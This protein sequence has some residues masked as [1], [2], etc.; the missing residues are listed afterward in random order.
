[1]NIEEYLSY[2]DELTN[3]CI[4]SRN[5]FDPNKIYFTQSS[6]DEMITK[7]DQ[8]FFECLDFCYENDLCPKDIDRYSFITETGIFG[9][10]SKERKISIC[11]LDNYI[12]SKVMIIKLKDSCEKMSLDDELFATHPEAIETIRKKPNGDYDLELIDFSC[13][14]QYCE[15]EIIEFKKS[16]L[17]I[18]Y[19]INPKMIPWLQS[20]FPDS[21]LYIRIQSKKLFKSP[22]PI[23]SL[24]ECLVPANPNWIK[25]L[26]IYN[27][28]YTGASY[29]IPNTVDSTEMKKYYD[30]HVK[31]IEQLDVVFK[32][33]GSGNLSGMIEELNHREINHEY[34]LGFCVH[35]DTDAEFG[36][37]CNDAVL[38]HLD[39]ALNYY[40]GKETIKNRRGCSLASGEKVTD[41]STRRHLLRLEKIPF[42]MIF[43]ITYEFFEGKVLF[44]EW[45]FQLLKIKT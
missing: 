31:G 21:K 7:K 16:Y 30:Y 13:Y 9:D 39:L 36:S 45:I 25:K 33:N 10:I 28:A 22:P 32:R 3:K 2:I 24:E 1:M 42:K 38:N 23:L 5:T 29:F 11:Y 37:D 43:P 41:A 34:L 12:M 44:K 19:G 6:I 17:Y 26:E 14:S 27:R 8:K 40:I 20:N 35:F 15:T 18:D 4:E